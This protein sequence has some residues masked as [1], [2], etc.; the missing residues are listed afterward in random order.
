MSYFGPPSSEKVAINLLTVS[1]EQRI[2][3]VRLEIRHECL[4][5]VVG[6]CHW[7]VLLSRVIID[8]KKGLIDEV[9]FNGEKLTRYEWQFELDQVGI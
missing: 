7:L 9:V 6:W 3:I 5:I 2:N 4:E 8:A 1:C